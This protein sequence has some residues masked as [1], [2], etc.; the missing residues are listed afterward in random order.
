[1]LVPGMDPTDP[2]AVLRAP[3]ADAFPSLWTGAWGALPCADAASRKGRVFLKRGYLDETH[4]ARGLPGNNRGADNPA[5]GGS[6]LR[7]SSEPPLRGA[8]EEGNAEPT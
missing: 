4:A 7:R 8:R 1:M 6:L 5:V 3:D 2:L